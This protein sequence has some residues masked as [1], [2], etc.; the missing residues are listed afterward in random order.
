MSDKSNLGDLFMMKMEIFRLKVPSPL[1][2]P[3]GR[4][5]KIVKREEK[6]KQ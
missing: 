1:L 4:V 2:G 5:P 6:L 3:M